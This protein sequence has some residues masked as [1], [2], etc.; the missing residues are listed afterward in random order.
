[1]KEVSCKGKNNIF[2]DW[3]MKCVSLK[4]VYPKSKCAPVVQNIAKT[5]KKPR[6][7]KISVVAVKK[8]AGKYGKWVKLYLTSSRSRST[9]SKTESQN[10]RV[11]FIGSMSSKLVFKL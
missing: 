2:D 5:T 9:L 8:D 6:Q 10:K 3:Q 11:Q 1:M 7:E 4:S